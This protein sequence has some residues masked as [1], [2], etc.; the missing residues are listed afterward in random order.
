MHQPSMTWPAGPLGPYFDPSRGK[1][2][3]LFED[4]SEQEGF[5]SL[6]AFAW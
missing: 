1:F 6:L 3:E 2:I 5:L 4:G